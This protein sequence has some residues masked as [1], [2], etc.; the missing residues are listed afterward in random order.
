MFHC[1]VNGQFPFYSYTRF[2]VFNTEFIVHKIRSN[3]LLIDKIGCLEIMHW[4][5]EGRSE[6]ENFDNSTIENRLIVGDQ[7]QFLINC[8]VSDD[9]TIIVLQFL[10]E[11]IQ[12]PIF[13]VLDDNIFSLIVF[14]QWKNRSDPKH[15]NFAV[16]EWAM[17]KCDYI[18]SK[19]I[20]S[21]GNVDFLIDLLRFLKKRGLEPDFAKNKAF[22]MSIAVKSG[23]IEPCAILESEF[24]CNELTEAN[25]HRAVCFSPDSKLLQWLIDRNCSVGSPGSVWLYLNSHESSFRINSEKLTF[26]KEK[27]GGNIS[28]IMP[29]LQ[30]LLEHL[31]SSVEGLEWLLDHI[32][33]EISYQILYIGNYASL[34]GF[35][36]FL[37]RLGHETASKNLSQ[38]IRTCWQAQKLQFL[39]LLRT[40]FAQDFD[41][42]FRILQMGKSINLWAIRCELVKWALGNDYWSFEQFL[43]FYF[44]DSS[45]PCP[46]LFTWKT[47]I[48]PMFVLFPVRKFAAEFV[49]EFLGPKGVVESYRKRPKPLD[50]EA[51]EVLAVFTAQLKERCPEYK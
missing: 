18:I 43:R 12:K 2:I 47:Y 50:S 3:I 39:R 22:L 31:T 9:D 38:L 35:R 37:K 25:F 10:E 20:V 32:A 24:N 17:D 26:I 1:F 49:D 15:P 29:Q 11:T 33:L 41:T 30:H 5:M 23:H 42:Q 4:A 27:F 13:N 40:Q 7:S 16:L 14:R 19:Q 6:T 34:S 46:T 36:V 51:K 21:V 45:K 28:D 44:N 48:L 8:N